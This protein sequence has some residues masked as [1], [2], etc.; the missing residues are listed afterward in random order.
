MD[1]LAL[2]YAIPAIRTHSGLAPVRPCSCR[3]YHKKKRQLSCLFFYVTVECDFPAGV[4]IGTVA[5]V[6][7]TPCGVSVIQSPIVGM[8]SVAVDIP[9]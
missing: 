5:S 9:A 4:C 3:A 6:W 1:T 7:I 2:G 8:M